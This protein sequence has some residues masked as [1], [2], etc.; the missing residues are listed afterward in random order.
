MC[1]QTEPVV[2]EDYTS[3][4]TATEWSLA[5]VEAFNVHTSHK[6]DLGELVLQGHIFQL[7]L[8]DAYAKKCLINMCNHSGEPHSA[9]DWGSQSV[10]VSFHH[11]LFLEIKG[12]SFIT[13]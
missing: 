2:S 13:T 6:T 8:R 9:P 4:D 12:L 3:S 5:H 11:K 1:C 10:K 7:C